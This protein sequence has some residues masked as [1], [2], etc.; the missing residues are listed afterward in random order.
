MQFEVRTRKNLAWHEGDECS[1]RYFLEVNLGPVLP[2]SDRIARLPVRWRRN[3]GHPILKEVYWV[4]VAGMRV[5]KGNLAALEA[6]VPQAVAAFLEH[7]TLPYYFVTT[8]QGSFPVYLVRGRLQLRT[9]TATLAADDVGE[10]W[11][12]L[13]EHL[14]SAR[15]IEALEE[16]EVSILLWSDL[17]VY[18]AGLLLRDG[19][20]LL[21][22]FL[23]RGEGDLQ[24]IYDVIGQPSRFLAPRELFSLR[25]ELAEALAARRAI[26]HPGALKMDR[27]REEVWEALAAVARPTPYVLVCHQDERPLELPVF[28]AQGE[29]FALQRSSYLRLI[30]SPDLEELS[31]LVRED[32]VL[33]GR[34]SG[35]SLVAVE[36]RR[37]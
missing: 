33:R 31:R 26:P 12:R 28:E 37:R 4:E 1:P 8:P 27:V 19:R 6:A 16:L 9:D 5:E 22:I 35:A 15:R 30:F 11:Q 25:R 14:H 7:G 3:R 13:A 34:A 24:L 29:F 2:G 23:R 21:P 10:L 20:V 36:Q 32:L 17:Q 18:P